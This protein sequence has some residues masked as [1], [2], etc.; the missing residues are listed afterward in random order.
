MNGRLL[1]LNCHEAW[2]HQLRLLH[3]PLDIVVG[4]PG[5]HTREW[6]AAIR[7]APPRSRLITLGEA[8]AAPD[9]YDCIIA[10]NLSDLFDTKALVGP[11]I[12][13]IHLTLEGMI[14]EQRAKTPA[15]DYRNVVVEYTERV[16]AHVVATSTLKAKSW[17]FPENIVPLMAD[18]GEYPPW[19]G[20]LACG[21]RV[22]NFVMRRAQTLLWDLHTKAFAGLP[23]KLVGH[24]PELP[25]VR[26]S[27]HWVE[28]K[29]IFRRH[30]FFIHTANPQL[31]DGYNMATLEAMAAGLPVLGNLHA[32]SPVVHGVSG[33]L[34][35]DPAELN[36][37]ARGLLADRDL[38]EEMGRAARQT[39]L[40]K[41]SGEAFRICMD[42]AIR[43]A[44]QKWQSASALRSFS[45]QLTRPRGSGREL[46]RPALEISEEK[47]SP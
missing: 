22:S 18:P 41:F 14:L 28:L 13:V 25:G 27:S 4:L 15:A 16:S 24:N 29:E 39:I 30:R 5:R 3:Y 32:S 46:R 7:P 12:L 19:G 9:Q 36:A 33:F 26:A 31:E 8:L 2:I 35:D 43:A 40:D 17:G 37:Y 23:I 38:A 10:H 42:E 20:D 6:D 11:R 44:Q 21:L 1:V 47:S 34:S 45:R